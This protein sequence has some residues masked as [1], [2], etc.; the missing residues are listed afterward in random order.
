MVY[1]RGPHTDELVYSVFSALRF[2]GPDTNK[3]RL[4]VYTDDPAPFDGLPVHIEVLSGR[5]LTEW[6]G[7]FDYNPR[8]KIF[9]IK[10]ALQKF[11]GRVA[12]LDTDTYFKKH[13]AKLFT[14]IRSRYSLMH[15]REG[16]L[17]TY[18]P[19]L[20]DFLED[21][22][23][24]TLD[25]CRWNITPNTLMWNSGVIGLDVADISLLD[26]V[27]HLIDQIYPHVRL[28]TTE[29]FAFGVCLGRFTRLHECYDIVYHYWPMTSRVRFREQ[30][31]R[32]LSDPAIPTYEERFRHLSPYR[33]FQSVKGRVRF[34]LIRLAERVG[35][36]T[37][38]KR[39]IRNSAR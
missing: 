28:Y 32:V 17:D 19:N 9:A 25:G 8:R 10:D 3:Y 15:I 2:L 35:Y 27:V 26:E 22:D 21:H 34:R 29:Q 7:P 13:P 37:E 23:L 12:Y 20:A 33:P 31:R 30:L 4:V 36:S 16:H 38:K 11:G 39:P 1:G 5:R 18:G 14:R 6:A 24:R